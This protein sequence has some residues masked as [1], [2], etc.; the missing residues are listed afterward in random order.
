MAGEPIM[1][2]D[3]SMEDRFD[4]PALSRQGRQGA[5]RGADLP[6]GR[7][8]GLLQVEATEPRAFGDEET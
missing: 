6:G 4:F 2:T 3:V 7:P 5:R 8:F 1:T